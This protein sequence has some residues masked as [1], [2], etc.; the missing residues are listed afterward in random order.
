MIE[1]VAMATGQMVYGA[2]MVAV[3][4]TQGEEFSGLHD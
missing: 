2:L 3:L 4:W 1:S